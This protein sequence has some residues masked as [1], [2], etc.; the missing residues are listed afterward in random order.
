MLADLPHPRVFF[1]RVANKGVNLDT[2]SRMAT[3]GLKMVVFS[4][5]CKWLVRVAGNGVI[6]R[7]LTVESSKLNKE[8]KRSEGN[9]AEARR[10]QRWS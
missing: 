9:K 1:V 5:S 8:R 3:A 6:E 2:A 7:R 4:A 10:T